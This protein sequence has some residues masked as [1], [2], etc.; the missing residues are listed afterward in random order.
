MNAADMPLQLEIDALVLM[1]HIRSQGREK[2]HVGTI[3]SSF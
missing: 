1:P 3:R 2:D